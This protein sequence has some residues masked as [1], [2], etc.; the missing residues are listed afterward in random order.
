MPDRATTNLEV[1]QRAAKTLQESDLPISAI[2]ASE[3]IQQ[4]ILN[5]ENG[6]G[7]NYIAGCEDDSKR[8]STA[9]PE[10]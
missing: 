8:I 5:F 1:L 4:V 7:T 9:I 3:E 6:Q 10:L 2:M